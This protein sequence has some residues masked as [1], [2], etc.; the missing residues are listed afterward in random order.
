[1]LEEVGRFV[2]PKAR[3]R[4]GLYTIAQSGDVTESD[5]ERELSKGP[6]AAKG[7]AV[8]DTAVS[9]LSQIDY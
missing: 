1:M 7:N 8:H 4:I 9:Q 3:D 5:K 2:I 6:I